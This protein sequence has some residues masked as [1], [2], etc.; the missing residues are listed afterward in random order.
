MR[1]VNHETITGTLSWYKIFPLN[2]FKPIRAK[3]KTSQE[4][5]KS[6][7]MFP[8]LSQKPEVTYTDNSLE[9]GKSCEDLSWIHRT[10][11]PHRSETNGNAERPVRRVKVGTSAV[12]L[13]SRL[14]ENW[15]GCFHGMLL[16]SSKCPGFRG[17]WENSV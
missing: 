15:W 14:D 17:R 10:S 11:K 3:Q 16:P 2:G 8:E 13:Q 9:F 5:E 4:T 6:L 1:R 12:L 7:R